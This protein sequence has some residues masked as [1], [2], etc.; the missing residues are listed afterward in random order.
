MH[1]R[2]GTLSRMALIVMTIVSLGRPRLSAQVTPPSDLVSSLA[3][4]S[5]AV[6][7]GDLRARVFGCGS[8]AGEQ[9][10]KDIVKALV[11]AGN[12]AIP[13]IERAL[14]SIEKL[15]RG[16]EYTPNANFLLSAYAQT[17]GPTAVKRLL[18]MEDN[19]GLQFLR[20]ALDDALAVS[21]DLTSYISSLHP[22]VRRSLCRDDEPRDALDQLIAAWLENDRN[23]LDGSLGP[24]AINALV[25]MTKKS[26]WHDVRAQLFAHPESVPTAVGYQF[27]IPHPWSVAEMMRGTHPYVE[28]A[29]SHPVLDT[30][31]TTRSGVVCG[32]SRISFIRAVGLTSPRQYFVDQSDLRTLLEVISQCAAS[33]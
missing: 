4:R 15:S 30:R 23:G 33:P 32:R 19:I 8:D 9:R 22:S 27:E 17:A 20:V 2:T 3:A 16:S 5:T 25:S 26:S 31:F 29:S 28:T 1:I 21:L 14:E 7:T 10:K 11:A 13:Q 12:D 6:D 24:S 18:A